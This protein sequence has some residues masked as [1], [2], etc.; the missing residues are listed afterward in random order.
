MENIALGWTNVDS[1]GDQSYS[2]PRSQGQSAQALNLGQTLAAQTCRTMV[3]EGG[4]ALNP[5]GLSVSF[6]EYDEM[7]LLELSENIHIHLITADKTVHCLLSR[8]TTATCEL[9]S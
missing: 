5:T 6:G 9:G 2:D 8:L 1:V 7:L 4:Q 3:G